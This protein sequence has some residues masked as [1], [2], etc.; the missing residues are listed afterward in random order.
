MRFYIKCINKSSA[1]C[2]VKGIDLV[3]VSPSYIS[4]TC[5]MC[6]NMDKD[7]RNGEI[8][9]CISCGCEMDADYNASINIRNRVIYSFSD[10][11]NKLKKINLYKKGIFF[12][13]FL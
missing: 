9:L 10:K 3:K 7:S 11:K 1:I 2:E 4:Q 12:Y 8:Y 13:F 5:S 6:G